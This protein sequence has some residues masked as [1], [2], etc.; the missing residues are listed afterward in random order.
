MSCL[1][2]SLLEKKGCWVTLDFPRF[3]H[4]VALVNVRSDMDCGNSYAYPNLLGIEL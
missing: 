1:F 4:F 3:L 2:C